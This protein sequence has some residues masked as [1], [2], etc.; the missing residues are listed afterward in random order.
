LRLTA[1]RALNHPW[2]LSG[3][4]INLYPNPGLSIYVSI[5]IFTYLILYLSVCIL[6]VLSSI[7]DNIDDEDDEDGDDNDNDDDVEYQGQL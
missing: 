4:V 2:I 5:C 6:N 1:K 7:P 3:Y